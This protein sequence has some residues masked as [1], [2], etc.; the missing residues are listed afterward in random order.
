MTKPPTRTQQRI[1]QM[2]AIG[3]RDDEIASQ[4]GVTR[5]TIRTHVSSCLRRLGV[6]SRAH[7]VAVSMREGWIS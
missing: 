1:L 5:T 2:I 4:Q 7:A 6:H 3:M